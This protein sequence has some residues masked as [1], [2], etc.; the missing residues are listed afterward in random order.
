MVAYHAVLADFNSLSDGDAFAN[1]PLPAEKFFQKLR[2]P[3]TL[4]SFQF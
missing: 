2:V 3:E 4:L 1:Y